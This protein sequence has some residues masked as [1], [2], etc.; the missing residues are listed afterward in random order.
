MRSCIYGAGSLGTVLGAYIT[1]NGG[2]V[3][4]VNRNKL[5]TQALKEKGAHIIG[6]VEKTVPV[7]ALFPDEMTGTYDVIILLTKQLLNSEVVAFLKPF[8]SEKGVICTL[9]NGIPEPLIASIIG[10]DHTMGCTVA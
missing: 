2:Q 1:E 8:L 6:T 10:N 4:L 3:D 9:Q 5:H 7:T